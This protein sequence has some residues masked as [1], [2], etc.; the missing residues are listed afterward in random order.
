MK[1]NSQLNSVFYLCT[2]WEFN[3]GEHTFKNQNYKTLEV[4]TFV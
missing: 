3:T 1:T 4:K 2:W